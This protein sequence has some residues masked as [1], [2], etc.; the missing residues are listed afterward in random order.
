MVR[1]SILAIHGLHVAS[2]VRDSIVFGKL[3]LHF[4][5]GLELLLIVE[6]LDVLPP[7]LPLLGLDLTHLRLLDP[8]HVEF[9]PLYL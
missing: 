2:R 5:V 3:L 9:G 1:L 8:L 6:T 7:L 4:L